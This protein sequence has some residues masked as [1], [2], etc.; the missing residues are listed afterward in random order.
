MSDKTYACRICAKQTTV[1][2][3]KPAPVCCGKKME[4]LPFC[5]IA[6]NPEMARNYEPEE[7]CD[8]GTDVGRRKR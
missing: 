7:P 4:P 2:D 1:K 8:N 5:T 3:T 6:P